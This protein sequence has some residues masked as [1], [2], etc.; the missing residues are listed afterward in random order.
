MDLSQKDCSL[1]S[2]AE[3]M[4]STQP[5]PFYPQAPQTTGTNSKIITTQSSTM[6]NFVIPSQNPQYG[7]LYGP[8]TVFPN[9][10]LFSPSGFNNFTQLDSTWMA[11]SRILS[12]SVANT[13]PQNTTA[14]GTFSPLTEMGKTLNKEGWYGNN[15]NPKYPDSTNSACSISLLFLEQN[16]ES[17]ECINVDDICFTPKQADEN[18]S[19]SDGSDIVVEESDSDIDD[20]SECFVCDS[21]PTINRFTPLNE[22][23]PLTACSQTSVY[24]KLVSMLE[25]KNNSKSSICSKCLEMI[26]LIDSLEVKLST[27]VEEFKSRVKLGKENRVEV[28]VSLVCQVCDKAFSSQ[29]YL[30]KHKQHHTKS[31]SYCC[32][33]CGKGFTG[34]QKLEQHVLLHSNSLKFQ[35]ELCGKQFVDKHTLTNHIRQHRGEFRYHC[36]VCKKGFVQKSVYKIHVESHGDS[37]FVCQHCGRKVKTYSNLQVHI[38]ICSGNLKHS[39]ETCDEKFPLKSLLHKHIAIKH[40][41][42]YRFTCQVCQKGFWKESDL[43]SHMKTHVRDKPYKCECCGNAYKSKKNLTHHMRLHGGPLFKCSMCSKSFTRADAL[44]DHMNSH[45][46]RKPYQCQTCWKRFANRINFNVH[47]KKHDANRV[48]T[49]CLVCK[50]NIMGSMTDHMKLH[51]DRQSFPCKLCPSLFSFK[52]SLMKHLKSKH[53]THVS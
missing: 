4:Y 21:K 13:D 37:F 8:Q 28:D 41:A 45:T 39:C 40:K 24:K 32:E 3:G 2:C 27:A 31:F 10:N 16:K 25:Q 51:G 23:S 48:G 20:S 49:K 35:C 50:R 26:N 5:F 42:K 9:P 11:Q 17:E 12:S 36:R 14:I 15:Q 19:S 46:G 34:L 38:R 1:P 47:V 22:K 43:K 6:F 7:G 44:T 30:T 53:K 29:A 18:S 52:N 33:Y